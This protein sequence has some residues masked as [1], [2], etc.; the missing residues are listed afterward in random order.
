MKQVLK[1]G[2]NAKLPSGIQYSNIDVWVSY[3]R[4]YELPDECTQELKD[5]MYNEN[6]DD[7]RLLAD[8]EIVLAT[9][10]YKDF[11]KKEN[12]FV[13]KDGCVSVTDV[14]N[15]G[16]IPPIPDIDKHADVGTCL[17]YN[18]KSNLIKGYKPRVDRELPKLDS[19]WNDKYLECVAGVKEQYEKNKDFFSKCTSW[20]ADTYIKDLNYLYRGEVDLIMYTDEGFYIGDV[21]KTANISGQIKEKYLMQCVAYAQGVGFKDCLG[22]FLL[23]PNS[24]IIECN[25]QPI[26]E[27][28]LIKRGEFRGKFNA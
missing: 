27:K 18:V 2:A 22:V 20:E 1:Y 8:K 15:Q 25:L 5:S 13:I 17:D 21:K 3:E 28:F 19:K 11:L 16:E 12:N 7:M 9:D 10:K 4:E 14:I 23:S 24:L 26:W 6:M